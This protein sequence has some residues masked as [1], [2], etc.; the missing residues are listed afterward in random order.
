[1]SPGVASLRDVLRLFQEEGADRLVTAGLLHA[2][3]A[4]E[5]MPWREFNRDGH[6]AQLAQL[7][8]PFNIHPKT[9][10]FGSDTAKGYYPSDF[11]GDPDVAA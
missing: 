5:D 4:N 7:L 8:R 6:A 3:N 11:R 2:L 1:M 10:R 9:I